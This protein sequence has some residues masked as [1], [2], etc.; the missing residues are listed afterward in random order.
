MG[1]CEGEGAKDGACW[2]SCAP[3]SHAER[4]GSGRG[5]KSGRQV[6]VV[7]WPCCSPAWKQWEGG[8]R[9]WADLLGPGSTWKRRGMVQHKQRGRGQRRGLL[10]LLCPPSLHVESIGSGRGGKLG[11][12]VEGA[13][14][15]CCSLAWKQREGG[16]GAQADSLG[17]GFA[18]K[19]RGAEK[20]VCWPSCTARLIRGDAFI[21]AIS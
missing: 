11:H 9:A 12:Q 20:G 16:G 3:G 2:P 10:A 1:W 5:G 21:I 14:W 6:E 8:G 17:P 13:Q 15:P 19:R 7:H 4:M 18:W